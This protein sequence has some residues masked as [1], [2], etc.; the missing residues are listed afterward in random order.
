MSARRWTILFLTAALAGCHSHKPAP[1]PPPA[2]PYT[3]ER[4][5]AEFAQIDP[6]AK[7]GLVSA[8]NRTHHLA[9]IS[10]LDVADFRTGDPITFMDTNRNL[11]GAGTAVRTVNDL[12]VVRFGHT[13]RPLRQGDLAVRVTT[14]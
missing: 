1:L 6:S 8:I 9:A 10:H 14:R 5:Q 13:T 12:L 4:L 7:V 3:V 11:L 2:T